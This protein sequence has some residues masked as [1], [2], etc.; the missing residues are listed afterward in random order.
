MTTFQRRY[1][2][3]IN[4]ELETVIEKFDADIT[5]KVANQQSKRRADENGWRLLDVV[6]VDQQ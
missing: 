5:L 6:K 1:F 2:A 3:R 4:G